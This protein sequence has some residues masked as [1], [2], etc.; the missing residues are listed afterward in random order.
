MPDEAR[1]D[2]VVARANTLGARALVDA[3]VEA[4]VRHVVIAPGSRSTPIVA[5]CAASHRIE[6]HVVHD[7]R[8]GAF[9]ALG[10]GRASDAPA[11]LVVTS[12]T[13]LANATPAVVEADCDRVPLVIVS[14][15]RPPEA[16]GTDANQTIDQQAFFGVR[17][18]A[19]VNLPP[20]DEAPAFEEGL[21]A[22]DDALACARG[23]VAGPVHVNAMYRKPLEPVALSV[24][25]T[26]ARVGRAPRARPFARDARALEESMRLVASAQRGVVVCGAASDPAERAHMG[27]VGRAARWPVVVEAL[28]GLRAERYPRAVACGALLA[29]AQRA[30]L[31]PDVVLWLGGP[32]VS[33]EVLAM[34]AQ[35]AHVVRV[36]ERGRRA[37]ER[38]RACTM[39][40]DDPRALLP[41][42]AD[43]ASH[44]ALLAEE[45][46][47]RAVLDQ[48]VADLSAPLDEPFVAGAVARDALARATPLFLGNSMPIRDVELFAGASVGVALANRGA[49]G[50]DGLCSTAAGVAIAARDRV[51]ALVGDI[52]FLHDAGAWSSLAHL[53]PGLRVVVVENGGGGIFTHLPIAQHDALLEKYFVTPHVVDLAALAR[54]YGV[55]SVRV[56]TRADLVAALNAPRDGAEIVVARVDGGR[57]IDARRALVAR[58]AASLDGAGR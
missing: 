8:S 11:A 37:P 53:A 15:D 41:A 30:P 57:Q 21:V 58:V 12:G 3:L 43:A 23:P 51:T 26:I 33:N 54:A 25:D 2:A 55:R 27:E 50:I 48:E 45:S 9:V 6:T 44:D 1:A 28:S 47:A 13:A 14:A 40:K 31:A 49:S 38:A 22:L 5:A 18:R 52:S 56:D 16:H 7:E 42:I 36:E 19:F 32:I 17:A 39:L 46:K 10:I 24:D 35:A 34:V 29:K 20:P 4:G